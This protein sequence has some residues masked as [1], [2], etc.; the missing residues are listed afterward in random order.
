[1][2]NLKLSDNIL[3]WRQKHFSDKRFIL[4][5]AFFVGIFAALAAFVLHSLIHIIQNLLTVEIGA[6]QYNWLYLI[7]PVIGIFI[8]MLFVHYVVRDNI[9]HGITRILYAISSK[10]SRLKAHN[11]WTSVVASAVTI[12]FGGSVGAEAPIVLTG[13][14]IAS[15]LGQL[16]RMNNKTLMLLVGCGAAA[17]IAGI[18]KAPIAGLV[19]TIEVLMIDLTMASISPILIASVTAT[20]FTYI[21]VGDAKLFTFTLED[22]WVVN[23]VPSNILLGI[24]CGL[25]SLY[26][27]RM[28]TFCEEIFIK[29][30]NRYVKLILGGIVLSSLLFLFPALYGEGYSSINILLSGDENNLQQLTTKTFFAG[31]GT[32]MLLAYVGLVILTKAFATASTN[33][34]GG[35][36]GTFAPS[37]FIGA[38]VGFLFGSLWNLYELGPFFPVENATLLG[39]AGVMSGVMHAPLTGVFLIAELTAGYDL[40]MPLMIVSVFAYLTILLFEPHSIYGMRLARQGKLITHHTDHSVLTLM[41]LDSVIDREFTPVEPDIE[42]GKLVHALSKSY[43]EVIPVLGP[44]NNL[45][46]EINMNKIRHIIFRTELY[47]HFK[48]SQLMQQPKAK[49]RLGDPIEEVMQAFDKYNSQYLPVIDEE[50]QLYGYVSRT[51]LLTQYRQM[52]ADFSNE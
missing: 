9:S 24:A 23:R 12:G 31:G 21:L 4:V 37:L 20:C 7:L 38:F 26:F 30:H 32:L 13:S 47:N 16:F 2:A 15:N 49:L 39:M 14:A 43:S 29:I 33:G 1:M 8:T 11:C 5:L 42:M 41:T 28:M 45:L 52:V 19:F 6:N 27:I 35:C 3:T 44:A 17:A 50:G 40:F 18:F 25:V 51:H 10:R 48:V 22:P 36:G 34:A 46:G